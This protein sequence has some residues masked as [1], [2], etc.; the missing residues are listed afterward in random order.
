MENSGPACLSCVGLNDL[1]FVPPGNALLTRRAKAK[2]SKNA[3]VVRFSKTRRRYERQGVLV[4]VAAL[5]ETLQELGL[6][7][8]TESER[9]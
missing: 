2:S 5:S 9:S 6:S 8:P 7:R 4:E 3:V 1:K